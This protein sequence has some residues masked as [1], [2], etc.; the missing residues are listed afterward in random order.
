M[1]RPAGRPAARRSGG[2]TSATTIP[3][4]RIPVRYCRLPACRR[5]TAKSADTDVSARGPSPPVRRHRPVRLTANRCLS[6]NDTWYESFS[7]TDHAASYRCPRQR[8][9]RQPYVATW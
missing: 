3:R 7:C 5:D 1:A 9:K 4:T 8:A 2:A 6:P